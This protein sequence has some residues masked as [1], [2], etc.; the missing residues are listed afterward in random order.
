MNDGWHCTLQHSVITLS[1]NRH[2]YTLCGLQC[3]KNKNETFTIQFNVTDKSFASG[4]AGYESL[5][6][7]F[8]HVLKE[9]VLW[10]LSESVQ[11]EPNFKIDL[12]ATSEDS[13]SPLLDVLDYV[14]SQMLSISAGKP[15]GYTNSFCPVYGDSKTCYGYNVKAAG[16][17]KDIVRVVGGDMAMLVMH[18]APL[19]CFKRNVACIVEGDE[20][21]I[22]KYTDR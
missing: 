7:C 19:D 14:G 18:G 3:K 4:R 8:N 22:V 13:I 21:T 9:D 11:I 6:Y 15:D 5:S 12:P 17:F 10:F 1:L 20:I 2:F 16:S